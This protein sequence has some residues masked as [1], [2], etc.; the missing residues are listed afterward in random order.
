MQAKMEA[1]VDVS[2]GEMKVEIRSSQERME[3]KIEASNKHFEALRGTL[4]SRM[5]IHQ[6]MTEAIQEEMKA[7]MNK[8]QEKMDAWLEEMKAW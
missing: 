8:N 7:K 4:F 3:A 6:A 5:D 2:L 1:K